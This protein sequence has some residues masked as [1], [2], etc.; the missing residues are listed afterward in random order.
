MS[1]LIIPLPLSTAQ[2]HQ[3]LEIAEFEGANMHEMLR[4]LISRGY[5]NHKQ[6]VAEA[7]EEFEEF[8]RVDPSP[9]YNVTIPT[10]PDDLDDE[11]PF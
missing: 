5:V 9:I 3:L 4:I 1:N 2:L 11:I 7:M 6:A 8:R 10:T